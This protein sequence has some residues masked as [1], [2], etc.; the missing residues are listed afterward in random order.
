MAWNETFF[1]TA[2]FQRRKA[3]IIE[4]DT[5]RTENSCV[6][7]VHRKTEKAQFGGTRIAQQHSCEQALCNRSTVQLGI[8][9]QTMN[10]CVIIVG[11][12][13]CA[14]ELTRH[15]KEQMYSL[16]SKGEQTGRCTA[17]RNYRSDGSAALSQFGRDRQIN[18]FRNPM[19]WVMCDNLRASEWCIIGKERT[20]QTCDCGK[21][22]LMIPLCVS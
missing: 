21:P 20:P 11:P 3:M 6:I 12:I 8:H 16:L 7:S 19:F 17:R 2:T 4:R 15:G 22:S 18:F 5:M 1:C 14:E 13:V 10:M 9:S